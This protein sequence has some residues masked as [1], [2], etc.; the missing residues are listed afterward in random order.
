MLRV[1]RVVAFPCSLLF[2]N[3][4]FTFLA[5][6]GLVAKLP[7]A[8]SFGPLAEGWPFTLLL[9]AF[10][11]AD[12]AARALFS[13]SQ[14]AGA[15]AEAAA[16]KAEQHPPTGAP[17]AAAS[18]QRLLPLYCLL[19]IVLVLLIAALAQG[20]LS[21]GA[22]LGDLA[23]VALVLALAFSNGHIAAA[24]LSHGPC[25]AAAEDRERAGFILVA[26]LHAGI[27]AGANLAL[28]W[29]SA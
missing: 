9:L 28:M 3:F 16:A 21:L 19:R 6:P 26:S 18:N 23:S 4:T 29:P 2:F 7:Y 8:G 10:G 15:A 14:A 24:A 5:F 17:S 12:L 20:W 27:V 13:R 1:C 25:K 11:L 22:V